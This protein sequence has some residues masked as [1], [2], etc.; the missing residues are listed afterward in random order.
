[1]GLSP[2]EL[3]GLLHGWLGADGIGLLAI[4]LALLALGLGFIAL[5]DEVREQETQHFDERVLLS[6]RR[7]DNPGEP[8][9][10]R[11]LAEAARDVTALGSPSVLALVVCA[12]SGFLILAR[13][14]RTLALVVCST[15]GGA[16]VNSLLKRVF[17]RPRPSVVPHL[18]QV[19]SESFPSG[20]AML[21]A[22]VYLTLG[23]LLAQLVEGRWRKAYLLS[24]ALGLTLL[25][26]LTRVYLG[27]HYPT[28]VVGGWMAGLAWALLSALVARAARRRSPGLREESRGH[29][30][31]S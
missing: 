15:V 1:M 30:A 14:W 7:P 4:L 17:A 6:L 2:R 21:S 24:V 20:H 8:I 28:D 22:I 3:R 26:G 9:G 19:L 25:I 16:V 11:W 27:V 29:T 10:P 12:V 31:P 18:T 23:A 5:S 13:R